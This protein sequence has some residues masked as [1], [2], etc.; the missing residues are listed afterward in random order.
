MLEKL[1][2]MI[3]RALR[4]AR[5]GVGELAYNDDSMRDVPERIEVSSPAF[6]DGEAIPATF[7]T[8]GESASPPLSWRGVPDDT[9]ALVLLIEDADSPTPHPLVHAIVWDLPPGDGELPIHALSATSS[10][11]GVGRNSLLKRTYLPIDPPRGHGPHYYAFQF[12]ACDRAL[13]FD[14]PPGRTALM[15]ALRDHVIAKGCLIGTYERT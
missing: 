15:E 13:P 14:A 9:E 8:D 4:S 11:A 2:S 1:P 5:P 12:F 10:Q 7:S 6:G 3:G